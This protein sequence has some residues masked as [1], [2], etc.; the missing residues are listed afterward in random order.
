MTN[1]QGF[2]LSYIPSTPHCGGILKALLAANFL[3]KPFYSIQLTVVGL[4]GRT[5]D[6]AR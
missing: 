5:G 2:E 3:F 6:L 4:T 1:L